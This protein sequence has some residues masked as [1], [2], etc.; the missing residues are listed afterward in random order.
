ML[1]TLNFIIFIE[2][3]I[4]TISV[5]VNICC[6]IE[7]VSIKLLLLHNSINTAFSI[8]YVLINMSKNGSNLTFIEKIYFTWHILRVNAIKC[9]SIAIIL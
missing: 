2:R 3:S 6:K 1:H 5:I 4:A 8:I 9:D 7:S